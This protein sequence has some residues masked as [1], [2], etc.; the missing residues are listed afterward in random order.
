MKTPL[1]HLV[2][3]APTLEAGMLA[4]EALL[5]TA[6][7]MG[8]QHKGRGTHNALV[9]LGAGCYLEIIAPDSNQPRVPPPLWMGVEMVARPQ[10]IAW[11]LK[12]DRL[13]EIAALSK[14]QGLPLGSLSEGQRTRPDGVVLR[15]RLI[16][17]STRLAEGVFPFFI[18]WGD[19]P[20]PAA[21]LPQAGQVLA[22]RAIHPFPEILTEHL[23]H[24]GVSIEV[25][26]GDVPG[27]CAQIQTPHGLV[28]LR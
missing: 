28:V 8:G 22:L 12:S 6:P 7:V 4:V 23:H 24:L 17:P 1:D 26:H 20:H 10:L 2:Y 27:L 18:D 9:G 25:V 15:W 5:H 14:R 13:P 16:E 11:A 3:A 19:S 21:A